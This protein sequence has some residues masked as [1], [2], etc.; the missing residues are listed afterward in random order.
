MLIVEFTWLVYCLLIGYCSGKA[1]R[2]ELDKIQFTADSAFS[3]AAFCA[4]YHSGY[5]AEEINGK[6][7]LQ[8][9]MFYNPNPVI[10]ILP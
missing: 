3:G 1:D 2:D 6:H 9:D 5:T 4:K 8:C 7:L 10:F